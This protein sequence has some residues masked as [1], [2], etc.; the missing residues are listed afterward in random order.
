MNQ[1]FALYSELS[2]F[3]VSLVIEILK[4]VIA[5]SGIM[6]FGLKKEKKWYFIWFG[7]A[8]S[9]VAVL[10]LSS[11]MNAI[12]LPVTA[13]VLALLLFSGKNKVL[14]ALLLEITICVLDEAVASVVSRLFGV[15]LGTHYM[16]T[17]S[18][19]MIFISLVAYI[20]QSR[21]RRG[22]DYSLKRMNAFYLIML[23]LAQF[24]VLYYTSSV[25]NKNGATRILMYAI[26][27]TVL[28]VEAVM[29]YSLNKKDYYY[30]ISMIN[31]Q[32]MDNQEKYY[33]NLLSHENEIRSFRHDV[34]NH[35][36]C[37]EA[38]ISEGRNDEAL[39]YISGLKGSLALKSPGVRT[40]NTIVS[41][42]ASDYVSK[43]PEV[44]LEW[45]G[46]IPNELKISR[47]DVC[48]IFS[49]ILG[50]AFESAV[51]S[52][53]KRVNVIAETVTNNMIVTVSN[54]IG[55]PVVIKDGLFESSKEDKTNHGI[56]TQNIKKSVKSNG[57]E[58]EFSFDD[59]IFT[60]K[61]V[62]P[63]SLELF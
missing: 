7:I 36:L 19:S 47:V 54:D 61:I 10:Y 63:N 5:M 16:L 13:V 4:L 51:N 34:K 35:F 60:V 23:A 29:I 31:Q 15:E 44:T 6:S 33:S 24:V 45:N 1:Y 28:L 17:G 62:L 12:T 8:V 18:V 21:K 3:V 52:E 49:N 53:G 20:L 27:S 9:V 22:L 55:A 58:T 39:E 30:N 11:A 42:I 14:Y 37:L 50:N 57:G 38:L 26:I 56:G 41:A 32:M 43:Y 48:T 2:S 25:H 59:K 40:G 46:L